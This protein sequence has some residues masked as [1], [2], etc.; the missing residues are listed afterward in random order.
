MLNIILGT[1]NRSGYTRAHAMAESE[2]PVWLPSSSEEEGSKGG[3]LE[4]SVSL[5]TCSSDAEVSLP[6][7]CC[8]QMDC[9][10]S[11]AADRD[12]THRL[13]ELRAGLGD[14]TASTADKEKAR[15][16]VL[17][18]WQLS[19]STTGWRR[20]KAWGVQPCCRNAIK[21]MLHLSEA[22]LCKFCKH[23]AQGFMDPPVDMRRT[24]HQR[25]GA[26]LKA[27][28]DSRQSAETLL[29]WV[30]ENM[31]EDLAENDEFVKAKKSLARVGGTL[32]TDSQGPR[33][34][35][36]LPPHTTLA[37]MRDMGLAFNQDIKPPSFAT[38]SRVYHESWQ[39]WL[40]VRHEGQHMICS[41]C[42][43]FKEWRKIAVSKE[44]R[45]L[46]QKHFTDHIQSMR[47]DR[48]VDAAIAKRARETV[49]GELSDP[50]RSCLSIVIDGMDA[51][52]FKMPRR[53]ELSKD[54]GSL[55]RPEARFYGC[56]VEGV[57]EHHF[58]ADCDLP[59]DANWD[60]TL[61][62]HSLHLA[63]EDLEKRGINTPKTLRL[64]AD[65]ATAELKNQTFSSGPVGSFTEGY[66]MK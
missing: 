56:L 19:S 27:V 63:H 25:A 22:K 28:T 42:Q 44:D 12:L 41:D 9:L 54:F 15:Y 13:D 66:S 16:D 57:T 23:L 46:V 6:D 55:W 47:A 59:K 3:D 35:R 17:R 32:L 60:L 43:R 64:H 37:E 48:K 7:N 62:S 61:L 40:K 39:D 65:N 50:D 38:F 10:G 53:V 58:L 52:K 31:A 45:D 8:C 26:N 14:G 24:Q 49:T 51:S 29:Q 18:M 20:W 34:V 4:E 5:P 36:S 33:Q 1:F 11:I 2:S 21:K 30:Y